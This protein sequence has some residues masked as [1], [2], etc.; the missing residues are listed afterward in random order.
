MGLSYSQMVEWSESFN[1]WEDSLRAQSHGHHT[2]DCLEKRCMERRSTSWSSLKGWKRAIV[3]Q[4]NTGTI[5]K[6]KVEETCE[7]RG[8]E[9]VWAFLSVKYHLELNWT[10]KASCQ[11]IFPTACQSHCPYSLSMPSSLQPVYAIFTSLSTLCHLHYSLSRPVSLHSVYAIF[12]TVCL[13]HL[14]Y[15]VSIPSSLQCVY[16]FFTTFCLC[17]LH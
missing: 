13:C 1:T 6:G 14:Q 8:V 11:A 7:R 15:S 16:A 12:T 3:N 5:S 10:E 17:H 4:T 9:C 2:I